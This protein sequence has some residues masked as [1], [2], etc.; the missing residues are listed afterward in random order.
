MDTRPLPA[1]YED[2]MAGLEPGFR[3]GIDIS[4]MPNVAPCITLEADD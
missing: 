4:R 2:I 3:G 1:V